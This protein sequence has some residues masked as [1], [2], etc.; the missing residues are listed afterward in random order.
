MTWVRPPTAMVIG[1]WN[2][3]RSTTVTGTP[4]RSPMEAMY[5]SRS[6]CPSSTCRISTVEPADTSASGLLASSR[7]SPSGVGIGSPCGSTVGVAEHGGHPIHQGVGHGMLQ[8]LGL[9]VHGVPGVAEEC[10]EV[11]FDQ[12]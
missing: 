12:A 3:C 7:M 9:V 10:D 1:P 5:R 6:G 4:G 8:S 11:G 2:G